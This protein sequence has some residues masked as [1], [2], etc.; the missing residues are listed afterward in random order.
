MAVAVPSVVVAEEEVGKMKNLFLFGIILTLLACQSSSSSVKD[1]QTELESYL[2]KTVDYHLTRLSDVEQQN[3]VVYINYTVNLS[4]EMPLGVSVG[5]FMKSFVREIN[6]QAQTT[7]NFDGKLSLPFQGIVIGDNP[8]IFIRIISQD[9]SEVYDQN[10]L[11]NFLTKY[12]GSIVG[13]QDGQSF[14]LLK[15]FPKT[16]EIIYFYSLKTSLTPPILNLTLHPHS[17]I[18]QLDI[19]TNLTTSFVLWQTNLPFSNMDEPN[20]LGSL[21]PGKGSHSIKELTLEFPTMTFFI[22]S[23]IDY[24]LLKEEDFAALSVV[25]NF[26]LKN[27]LGRSDY[28]ALLDILFK[29]MSITKEDKI[30]LKQK[31]P[32]DILTILS[33]KLDMITDWDFLTNYFSSYDVR[34]RLNLLKKIGLLLIADSFSIKDLAIGF[35]YDSTQKETIINEINLTNL[36]TSP[37]KAGA[38]FTNQFKPKK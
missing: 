31:S 6:I 17:T 13:S 23:N 4:N 29:Q 37:L 15:A 38:D 26:N 16:T 20:K 22:S 2:G 3:E 10:S 27:R 33:H 19:S 25:D 1:T 11:D 9:G 32:N 14:L 24:S 35:S 36:T 30:N 34:Y 28:N 12:D 5:D 18:R 8:T 21:Q 7:Q